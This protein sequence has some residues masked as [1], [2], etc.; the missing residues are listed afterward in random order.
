MSDPA[1]VLFEAALKEVPAPLRAPVENAWETLAAL[2]G[3]TPDRTWL[4]VLPRVLAAS[5]F[6][7]R[8]CVR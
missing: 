4:K 6:I 3:T 8:A 7:A 5:D 2:S 1:H